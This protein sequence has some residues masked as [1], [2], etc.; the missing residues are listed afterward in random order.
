MRQ[1]ALTPVQ[2][3][4]AEK[5]YF[6]GYFGPHT[7]WPTRMTSRLTI[8]WPTFFSIGIDSPTGARR[9]A[10]LRMKFELN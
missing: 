9:S 6:W 2:N 10:F 7:G 5:I 4:Q 1:L 8:S 3:C